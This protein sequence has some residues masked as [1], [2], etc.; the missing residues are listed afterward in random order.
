MLRRALDIRLAEKG[1]CHSQRGVSHANTHII[2]LDC[3]QSV[4]AFLRFP[5]GL[6]LGRVPVRLVAGVKY[7]LKP[8]AL[9]RRGGA[10]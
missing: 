10:A 2:L 5:C 6:P 7:P 3:G 4:K 9:G 1:V 8:Q